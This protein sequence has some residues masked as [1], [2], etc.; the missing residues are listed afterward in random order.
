MTQLNQIFKCSVCGNIVE[1]VHT[2]QGHPVCC[3]KPMEEMVPNTV[4]AS[5]EKHV[6]VIEKIEEG[7]LVKIGSAAHP[8]VEEHFIEWI[9]II[10]DGIVYR[11]YLKPGD[12]PEAAFC[13]Q[14]QNVTARALCNIH[15]LW[16]A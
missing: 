2:G 16:Q 13:V 14:A 1:M 3:G 10:A 12:A 8:M 15:G 6:P 9:E 5:K 11:R 7:V 4:D